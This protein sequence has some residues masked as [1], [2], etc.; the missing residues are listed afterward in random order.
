MCGQKAKRIREP[1]V[2]Q[3]RC[4]ELF[5]GEPSP[6]RAS[7]GTP[8]AQP[9]DDRPPQ[10]GLTADEAIYLVLLAVAAFVAF[11]VVPLLIP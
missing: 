6:S 2:Y 1:D 3:C 7:I 4:G 10:S 9:D 8:Q 11:C 5:L